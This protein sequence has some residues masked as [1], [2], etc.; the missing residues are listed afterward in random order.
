MSVPE[1]PIRFLLLHS[2]TG[3]GHQ[4]AAL[5]VA[6]AL[7]AR[8]GEEAH[9]AL[10]DVLAAYAPWPFRRLPEWY[11][12]ML[13]GG[14][15]AYGM[16]YRLLDRQ[17]RAQA[18]SH[19]VWPWVRPAARRLLAEHPADLLVAFHPL[20]VHT[21]SRALTGMDA[22]APLVAMGT[23]LVVMHAFYAARGIRRYLV[24]TEAAQAQLVRHG[25]DPA[26]V[27]VVGLPVRR[28]FQ[29]AAQENPQLLRHRLG[30][31]PQQSL[32]L[33]MGGGTGFGPLERVARAVA[34][35][36][37]PAQMVVVT[38]RN[39]RL[40][41]RLAEVVWPGP[42]RVMGFVEN[43][44]EWMR[45]ADILVTKAGPNTIAEALTLGLPMVL[46]GAIPAQETPNLRLAVEEGVGTWAPG[47][48]R[49]AMAVQRLLSDPATL[50]QMRRKARALA[51][52]GAAGRVAQ[53]LWEMAQ[54][55]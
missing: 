27:E 19:L 49:A 48:A 23:D 33:V 29:E 34:G 35:N 4:R 39:E 31:D 16:G 21:V 26:R 8:Y 7:K 30:L 44:H 38:G 2:K 20:P 37:A 43:I 45:A 28:C 32:V 40:R 15:R 1:Q 9:V 17:R 55:T 10:L 42:V 25:V 22:P 46:W 41:A 13:W 11:G 24:A 12:G 5:A 47:P 54:R 36:G 3:G 6:E 50:A 51:R 18:I 14:G 52:P 53:L